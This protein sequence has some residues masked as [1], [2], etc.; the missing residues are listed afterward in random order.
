MSWLFLREILSHLSFPHRWVNWNSVLL[1]TAS[2]R[3]ML[4]GTLGLKICHSRGLRLGDPLSPMLFLLVMEVLSEMF[5]KADEWSLLHELRDKTMPFRAS[6]YA[7][8]VILFICPQAQDLQLMKLI[9]DVFQ[10]ASGLECNLV[11]CQIATIRCNDEQLQVARDNFPCPTV[12]F[13]I[14][15]LGLSLAPGK[16][17]HSALQSL[18]DRAV[19]ALPTWKGPL[20]HKS[21]HLVLVKTTLSAMPIYTAINISL[22]PW[23]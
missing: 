16:L 7:D 21:G 3:V 4:N 20:M 22:P 2:T 13:L 11:K 12:K 15:Y 8:D 6:F 5:Q 19:D 10:G 17:P 9:F 1:S 23:L 18:V 14:K